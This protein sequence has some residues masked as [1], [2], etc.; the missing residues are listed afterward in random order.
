MKSYN[1]QQIAEILQTNPETVRRWIRDKKLHA[2]QVSRKEGNVVTEDELQRFLKATPKYA[3]RFTAGLMSSI[4][5]MPGVGVPLAIATLLGA[6]TVS[7]LEERKQLD[8]RV[9]SEE[10]IKYIQES[11]SEKENSIC[12][13]KNT[14]SQLQDEIEKEQKELEN[15]RY[16]LERNDFEGNKKANK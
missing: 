15:L 10:L 8:T 13:K 12:R 16:L 11:I 6:K 2:V 3:P 4:V 14:I 9:V 5:A 7:Y 1:V